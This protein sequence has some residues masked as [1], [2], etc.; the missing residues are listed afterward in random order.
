MRRDRTW[1]KPH[2]RP[3]ADVSHAAASSEAPP[4]AEPIPMSVEGA[5]KEKKNKSEKK[6]KK[7]REGD[8]DEPKK[9]KKKKDTDDT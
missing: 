2:T 7:K 1:R 4:T 9:K 8:D 5:K 3:F 6:E